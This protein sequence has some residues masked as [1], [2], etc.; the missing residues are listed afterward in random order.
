M[1]NA[2]KYS[3]WVRMYSGGQLN[4]DIVGAF[5]VIPTSE[6]IFA[7]GKGAIDIS[8]N[9]G[10]DISQGC[11]L[12]LGM[13]QTNMTPWEERESGIWDFYREVLAQETNTYWLGHH[14]APQWWVLTSNVPFKN[15]GDMK[16][17]KI[18]AGA[19]H[20]AAVT[21]LG[22]VPVKT[23][24]GDIYTSMERGVV[25]AFIYPSSGWAQWGWADVTKYICGPRILWG[26]NSA[27][28]I[29]LDVWKS[30]TKEQQNWLT[31]PM[32]DYELDMYGF[33]YW[34]FDGDIYGE[35]AIVNAGVQRIEWTKAENEWFEKTWRDA[36][37]K[38]ALGEM[39]PDIAKRFAELVGRPYTP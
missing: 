20:F 13:S 5:D 9:F 1:R 34:V 36:S 2:R 29:N 18:R 37:W 24:V 17:K 12:G 16:G 22:A 23:S 19:T 14:V 26:Q 30:L 11:A 31:Q 21:A 3:D 4:I 6:Q 8:F 33:M 27:P 35:E 38:Y 32:L 10:D 25:D 28:L 39:K 15:P 7:V